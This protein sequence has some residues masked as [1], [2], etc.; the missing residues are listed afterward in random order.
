[1]FFDRL[2]IGGRDIIKCGGEL[3]WAGVLGVIRDWYAAGCLWGLGLASLNVV[4]CPFRL[5]GAY[6]WC[7]YR[8]IRFLDHDEWTK[9]SV[10]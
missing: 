1:M 6:I 2:R 4:A 9:E 3:L 7:K 8:E 5:E 10:V